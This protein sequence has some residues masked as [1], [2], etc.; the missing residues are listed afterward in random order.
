MSRI[1]RWAGIALLAL[2]PVAGLGF[3]LQQRLEAIVAQHDLDSAHRSAIVIAQ[4][5][6][7]PLLSPTEVEA[8][9]TP[10]QV[11]AMD[12][13]LAVSDLHD[14]VSRLKVWNRAGIVVYSDRHELIGTKYPPDDELA[15]ALRGRSIADIT[16]ANRLEN[17]SDRL[18]GP[19]IEVYVPLV[20][21]SETPPAGAFEMYL[22]YSETKAAI[23]RE[24]RQLSAVLFIGLAVV[25][26]S[27]L[28]V[29]V[30]GY[31]WR[32]RLAQA[33]FVAALERQRRDDA[34]RESELKSR[35]L[36]TMSHELRTPLNSVLGFAQLLLMKGGLDDGQLRYLN[37]IEKSGAHLVALIND[38]LDLNRLDAGKLNMTPEALPLQVVVEDS[39]SVVAP[40][41]AAA[42]LTFSVVGAD[43]LVVRGDRRRLTQVLVNLFSNSVKFTDPGG[44]IDVSA[45]GADADHIFID[46]TDTGCGIPPEQQP[47]V[48]DEFRQVEMG[49]SRPHE[50]A[51]L[52]LSISRRLMRQMQGDV[53]LLRSSSAGTTFRIQ[54]KRASLARSA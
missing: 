20:F 40:L 39:L 12:Q 34:E 27:L 48:F 21:A 15:A 5:G 8:G 26:I 3:I 42:E 37:N 19:L 47:V 7:Q 44:R 23:D 51:G 4:V 30:A 14:R 50:G 31:R 6:I 16:G 46:V 11:A 36:A 45:T 29:A 43:D 32:R 35:F 33:N 24:S 13:S 10:D 9:L 18:D 17:A 52:G 22:P 41:A 49:R 28:L 1:A 2:V 54:A 53:W 38:L 25:Y